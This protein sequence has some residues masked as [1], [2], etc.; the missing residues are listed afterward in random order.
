MAN[1]DQDQSSGDGSTNLQAGRDVHYH[2]MTVAEAR[3]VALDVFRANAL[4]LQGIAQSVAFARAEEITNDFLTTLN[5]QNPA[6][7]DRL[8]DP[9]M[10]SV[11]FHAQ[12]EYAR[13]GEEDLKVALVDL[14]ASRADIEDREL[15][16]LAINE[17]IVSAPKLTERQRRAV[18]W[19]FYLKY[20]RDT[21]SGTIPDFYTKFEGVVKALGTDVA[22]RRADYQHMEYVGVGSL[23]LG[24]RSFSNCLYG[25]SEALF[26]RGFDEGSVA[27]EVVTRLRAVNLLIPCLRDDQKLQIAELAAEALPSRLE[28]LGLGDIKN[29]VVPLMQLG[30]MNDDEITAEA[31]LRVPI[32]KPLQEAWDSDVGLRNFTLTSVGLALGH[33]YWSRLTGGVAPLSIWIETD[34]VA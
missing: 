33:A 30:R 15:R 27:P 16:A 24:Q 20:T 29:Q 19:I 18:A 34:E 12:K 4:E 32:S 31:I 14:L 25:G 13:S 2:G 23:S 11:L 22:G 21:G 9:D 5:E 26:T 10:Q 1:R 7:A 17:A 3:E 8:S 6:N 28:S